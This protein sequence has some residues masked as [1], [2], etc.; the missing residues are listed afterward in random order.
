MDCVDQ[1]YFQMNYISGLGGH[2]DLQVTI[3]GRQFLVDSYYFLIACEETTPKKENQDRFIHDF[4]QNF[5]RRAN[6]ARK[7]LAH[8][9]AIYV[10]FDLGDEYS[11][12][13][14]FKK[15]KNKIS[16]EIGLSSCEGWSIHLA[17]MSFSDQPAGYQKEQVT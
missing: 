1:K 17:G 12:W 14:C 2:G 4:L 8:G 13:V 9:Q 11:R 10:P 3:V 6:A 16:N 7:N 5:C 15:E